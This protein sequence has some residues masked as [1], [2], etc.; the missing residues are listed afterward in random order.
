M[1][2]IDFQEQSTHNCYQYSDPLIS[3]I[4]GLFTGDP[5]GNG[6]KQVNC[7]E[8]DDCAQDKYCDRLSY[9]C[10]NVCK[11][12]ICGDEAVCTVENH[13][14]KCTCPPGYQPDPS[15]EVK[16]TKLREGEKCDVG[17]CQLSC[18]TNQQCPAGQT[19]KDGLCAP[20]CADH[21]DCPGQH[22][23]VQGKAIFHFLEYFS[24]NL[25]LK[26]ISV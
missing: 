24:R 16:C 20:G 14:H 12:G 9:T 22:V 25:V 10:M 4:L 18:F 7:L 5:Y 11:T 21:K 26:S 1:I 13:S 8:N 17:Q 6:C 19:C 2:L 3:L 23:C 15:P